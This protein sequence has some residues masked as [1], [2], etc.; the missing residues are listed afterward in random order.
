MP[1]IDIQPK[2]FDQAKFICTTCANEWVCGT[3]KGEEVRV[4]VCSNC[5]PFY[6]G[7]QTYANVAGRVEQFR[8][9]F[10]KRDT[11]K[12]EAQKQSAAQK[13]KNQENK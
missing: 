4:D 2:Y 10:A 11:I 3:S 13:A 12:A 7:A 8:S 6:T 1:K 9:K 5:H